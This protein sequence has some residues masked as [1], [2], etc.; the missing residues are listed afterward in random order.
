M[1]R[2]AMAK[3][4]SRRLGKPVLRRG[5]GPPPGYRW[6]VEVLDQARREADEFLNDD[7]YEHLSLQVKELASQEDPTHS[8]TIDV[9]P[10]RNEEFLEIRDKGGVLRKINVRVFFCV[11]KATRTI[12]ILGTIKKENDGPTPDEAITTMRSRRRRYIDSLR[13][14]K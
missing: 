7:Q 9:R 8:D 6:N 5:G 14:N 10:I 12:A 3:E 1:E 11:V 2:L 4:P 13:M